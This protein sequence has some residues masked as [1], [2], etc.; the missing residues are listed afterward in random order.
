MR[1]IRKFKNN[2]QYLDLWEVFSKGTIKEKN[3]ALQLLK[4]VYTEIYIQTFPIPSEQES[5]ETWENSCFRAHKQ[6]ELDV[7][8]FTIFGFD[9][10]SKP[11]LIAFIAT[12]FYKKSA[13]ALIDY[14]VRLK[15]FRH[16]L[17]KFPKKIYIKE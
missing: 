12:S 11:I 5:F 13:T 9:L 17:S 1:F 8:T 14:I 16:I 6:K 2:I 4:Q 10:D 15:N 3:Y 7:Q